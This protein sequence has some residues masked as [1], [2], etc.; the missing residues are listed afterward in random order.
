MEEQYGQKL[1]DNYATRQKVNFYD[2][3]YAPIIQMIKALA[4]TAVV[5]LSSQYIGVLGISAGM[6]AA[7][8][9]L[10]SDLLLPIEQID[11]QNDPF[12]S[13]HCHEDGL[14]AFKSVILDDNVL[15]W[16]ELGDKLRFDTRLESFDEIVSNCQGASTKRNN[17]CHTSR[18]AQGSPV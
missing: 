14:N 10:I 6:L 16:R 8:L 2:S 17:T 12:I 11:K 9:Q 5:L 18:R 15:T 1:R 7:T 3:A 4:I 13:L